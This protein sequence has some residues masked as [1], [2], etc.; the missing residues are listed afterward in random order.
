MLKAMHRPARSWKR[1]SRWIACTVVLCGNGRAVQDWTSWTEYP[2]NPVYNPGTA[3]YPSVIYDAN[4]FGDNSAY[5][6]MWYQDTS[7]IGLAY[8]DDGINWVDIDE[9]VGVDGYLHP[10]VIYDANGFGG[11][12]YKYKLW[13]WSG[14]VDGETSPP[15]K[16]N[17]M[18][19]AQST[20]GKNWVNDHQDITQPDVSFPLVDNISGSYFYHCYGPGTVVYHP[21]ATSIPGDPY[22]YPYTMLYDTSSEGGGPAIGTEQ[23]ALAYSADGLA[24]V[25]YGA[26]PILIPS[27]NDSDWD[28]QYIYQGHFFKASGTYHMYY[29]GSNGQPLGSLGNETAH[30]LGYASSLDGLS[31]VRDPNPIFIVTDGVA[32]RNA[33]TYTVSPLFQNPEGTDF[34]GECAVKMW[35][36]GTNA[37]GV[38]SIGYATLPCPLPLCRPTAP[39]GFVG[40][41]R[42][43]QF[44][45]QTEFVL[46]TTWQAS[47]SDD[48]AFYNIYKNGK[49]LARVSANS[50]LCWRDC[51]CCCSTPDR[52]A[53]SAVDDSGLESLPTPMVL[54]RGCCNVK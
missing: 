13:A 46:Q 49:V 28:G 17:A 47:T 30:G 22:S 45:T 3:Y 53:I 4:R 6:K 18:L 43:N 31:W 10:D 12:I 8:S 48:I 15:Y 2:A 32:W 25:R 21:N 11:T 42:S 44:L 41:I 19:Y 52:Y 23:T 16:V 34:C 35:F 7:G 9:Q 51:L 50:T 20:D 24:W 5:Y 40:V 33:R 54:N 26:E 39:T 1:L 37:D 14:S 38:K 29:S 27:G 36:N